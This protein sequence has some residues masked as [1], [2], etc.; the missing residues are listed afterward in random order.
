MTDDLAKKTPLL[1]CVADDVTGA[2]DMAINL[3]QGGMRVVQFLS[4]PTADQLN[5]CECD[6][7]VVA[8]KTRSVPAADAVA[9]SVAAIR[10]LKD[11]G[12]Q[13]FFFKYCST[14]D[15][16]PEGNIGPVADA[17]LEYLDSEQTIVCPAFPRTGRTVYHS[18]LFVNGVLLN[19]SG[20]QHHPL[21]PMTD[22]NLV[23]WLGSQTSNKV[24][25]VGYEDVVAGSQA[26]NARMKELRSADVTFAVVDCCEDGHLPAIAEAVVDLPLVTGGSGIG[27]FLPDAW[28][29]KGLLTSEV[30]EPNLPQAAGRSLIIAGSCS[31][32]TQRQVENMMPDC[33][34]FPINV[35]QLM[36]DRDAEYARFERWLNRH[37][38]NHSVPVMVSSS[39]DKVEVLALQERYGQSAVSES[40]EAFHADV[41]VDMTRDH[42]VRRLIVAGGETSGA[43]V[44]KLGITKLE[45]GPEICAGVLWTQADTDIPLALALKSGNFGGDDFFRTA[46]EMLP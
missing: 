25:S 6:A 12:C 34:S 33:E 13:R 27:R 2:T 46:L 39:A 41:A 9:Q 23:R 40:I 4:V 42:G 36:E 17:I 38:D 28:R 26:I 8:L 35:S 15:S 10:A 45:I 7:V 18:H 32:A 16:T 11:H 21:N 30:R 3:V 37:S 29:A 31:Q 5:D 1:G 14:F 43:V 20:M 24:G 22:A 19:E 44:K